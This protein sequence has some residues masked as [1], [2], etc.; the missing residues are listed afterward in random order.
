MHIRLLSWNIWGGQFLPEVTGFLGHAHADIIALQESQEQ[1]SEV[2]TAKTIAASLGYEYVYARSMQYLVGGREMYRGNAILSKYP[3][4]ASAVHILS[5]EQSR[6]AL[7][8]D[9]HIDEITLHVLSVH[10]IHSHQHPSPLQLEQTS[11]LLRAAP[12]EKTVIM[13]DFNSLPESEPIRVM[14]KTFTDTDPAKTPSWC[15]YPDGC[16]ICKPERVEWKL[17]YIFVSRD[18][19]F[20]NFRVGDSK[21][22]DHLPILS[23]IQ[24]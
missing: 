20:K 14:Q 22:S 3:I 18:I 15:L 5:K 9:I 2:N 13:G 24:I 6:T 7:Q 1:D 4:T 21:G 10:L 17:D 8:A 23:D 19:R 16:E 12:K 11:S